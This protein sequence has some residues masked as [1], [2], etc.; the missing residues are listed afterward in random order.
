MR[1]RRAHWGR[2]GT[3][4]CLAA[5]AAASRAEDWPTYQHDN[6]R[7]GATSEQLTP[8][9]REAWRYAAQ[10]A[11]RPAWPA[12][13]RVDFAANTKRLLRARVTYDRAFHV[14]TVG[15][16]VYFAS[17]ADDK[18]Y[19]LDASTGAE[20]WS[21]FTGGPVRL[22]PSV[23]EARVYVGSDDGWAY[24]LDAADGA[25][26]WKYNP[27]PNGRYVPGNSRMISVR[28]VRTG[29][30]VQDGVAYLGAGLFPKEGVYLCALDARDGA[31]VWKRTCDAEDFVERFSSVR[32]ARPF[33][34][35]PQ[36]YLL[37]S[38][39]RLYVPTGRT[40]PAIVDRGTGEVVGLLSCPLGEGGTYALL[41]T[42]SIMSG[43]G[44]RLTAYDPGTQDP[45]ASF[46][47][48]RIIVTDTM[49][50]LLSDAELS[51]VDRARYDEIMVPRHALAARGREL[52]RGLKSLGRKKQK[53]LDPDSA[54]TLDE[55]IAEIKE[56]IE[57]VK[58][59]L[60]DM[61]GREYVWRVPCSECYAMILARDVLFVGGA[62]VVLAFRAS[63]G[64]RVWTGDVTGRA[65]GLAAANGR[66]F[67]STDKG[68]IHCF[69]SG[70]ATKAR[71]VPVV[72]V[73]EPYPKGALA[74]VYA[75]AA[76]FIVDE[77]GITQGY[78]LDLGCGEARLAYELA[79]RTDLKIVAVDDD[80]AR[81]GAAR[82]ALDRAGVYGARV[83]VLRAPLDALPFND[84]VANL[85][86]SDRSLASGDM[87]VDAGEVARL[88]RPYGGIACIGQTGNSGA[89][90]Q[91]QSRVC[92]L[93]RWIGA[94]PGWDIV[95]DRGGLWAVMRRGALPGSGEWTHQYADPGNSGCSG[96]TLV[97]SPTQL[98]WFGRP[99]PRVMVDRHHR[100]MPPLAKHGRLFVPADNRILAVD[101]YNGTPLWDVQVPN[102]RRI[103]AQRDA[104]NMAVADDYLYAA[105]QDACWG[106]DVA[107]GRRAL[108]FH[109][110]QH[111]PGEKRHWGYT[112]TVDSLL[113]GSGQKEKANYTKISLIGDYEIQWNDFKRIVTCDYLFCLDRH[114]GEEL[115]TYKNG[116]IIHPTIAI[117]DGRMYFVESHSEDALVNHF[118]R[119]T[120]KVLLGNGAHLVALDMRTGKSLWD[121]AVDLT[122]CHH[123]IYL[124]Y[125]ENILLV[126]GSSNRENRAW[127]Y[128]YT[129]DATTGA[130]L[131]QADHPNNRGGIGG[132]H[133]EQIHHP[134]IADGIV[135]AEP[136]AY[137]LR[138]G[139]RVD[140]AHEA[141]DWTLAR[142][143]GC[144]TISGSAGC[145]YYRDCYPCLHD[146]G[147]DSARRQLNYVSRPGCWINIVAAG[148]LVLI[149]EASSGC[150]CPHPL[151]TSFAYIPKNSG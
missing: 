150:S 19:A 117:G 45:V 144:G 108:T 142:R 123:V 129:F 130:P 62:G 43:P 2:I 82:A 77:T 37:A 146:L 61:E 1:K 53:T 104:G 66:L 24:C 149:P 112:A 11:P 127:Y 13:A 98:Q 136:A 20:R 100:A 22:A 3:L 75:S 139:V 26:I 42:E 28:P 32:A 69:D 107:T 8:P 137:D 14:A 74:E 36:G 119:M 86:V 93:R 81:V 116:V 33:G 85:I 133:G 12:P 7:S 27:A 115:W 132:D 47:G 4:V 56:E 63:D 131:W 65:Y 148:G 84:Y 89:Q 87:P 5:L 109:V 114:T 64:M 122:L 10:H 105:V 57:A 151:Q 40:T 30:L 141:A 25:L 91:G 18:V 31:E 54:R 106:L 145:L 95:E 147:L 111:A 68:V 58:K 51:A 90:E 49:S 138:S 38:E 67:V 46:N 52:R 60:K 44:T 23:F 97:A 78:C 140:P 35:S 72:R 102:S 94:A 101:A 55:Q 41:T 17:S 71:H 59:R 50:Y 39:R 124:S 73:T 135:F 128:L 99:G 21:F 79:R 29:V 48:R 80:E 76:Q 83:T 92:A 103:A 113:F 34:L 125:A 70:D 121:H 134:V 15:D 118:G 120:L 16:T 126:L 110:P 6:R 143:S 96:D 9:L 88:L